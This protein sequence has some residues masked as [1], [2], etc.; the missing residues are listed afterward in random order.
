VSLVV[1]LGG[2]RSGKS[3]LALDFAARWDGPVT[4]I[5]TAEPRDDEMA[6]RIARHRAERPAGWTTVE[7]PVALETALA[8]APDDACVIVDCLALWLSNLLEQGLDP[9]ECER[10]ATA[11]ATTAAVRAAT[12]IVVSNEVGL[13]VVPATPLGRDYRDLLGRLN[14]VWI[15]AAD[16]AALVVAGRTLPLDS[17]DWLYEATH[18]R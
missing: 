6:E 12:T 10:A 11:A 17:T 13:G 14:Q 7:E 5:A 8:G 16:A 1:L 4:F 18:G 2:A 15:A 3:R 9:E